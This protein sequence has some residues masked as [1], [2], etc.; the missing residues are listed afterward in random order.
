VVVTT[1]YMDEAERCH[2]LAFIFRG[3]V[4]DIG[5]PTEVVERRG[6]AVVELVVDDP[7]RAS[8]ALSAR[9]EVDECSHYGTVLRVAVHGGD[10]QALVRS[11]L[12]QAGVEIE[13]LVATR[14]TVED[15]FVSMVRQEAA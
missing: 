5:T 11:V 14:T 6:L 1:H 12:A 15:A 13:A 9:A 3:T 8:A 10:P 4:L 7:V 2:R